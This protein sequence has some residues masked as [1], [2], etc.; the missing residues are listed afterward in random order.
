MM[1]IEVLKIEDK[2]AIIEDYSLRK[3]IPV[4]LKDRR[5]LVEKYD[6]VNMFFTRS[7]LFI[8]IL[9]Q[10]HWWISNTIRPF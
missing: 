5:S 6:E 10:L 8:A 7:P 2:L 1:H 4:G 3:K 9:H